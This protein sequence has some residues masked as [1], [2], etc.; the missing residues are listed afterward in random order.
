MPGYAASESAAHM[1]ADPAI[2]VITNTVVARVF[3][4]GAP[5]V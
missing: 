5:P 4:D 2:K 3:M 1:A